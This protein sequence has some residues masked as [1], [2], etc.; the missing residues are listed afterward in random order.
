MQYLTLNNYGVD[1][2]LAEQE[3]VKPAEE[4]TIQEV[5]Q[6]LNNVV[7]EIAIMFGEEKND[8]TELMREITKSILKDILTEVVSRSTTTQPRQ[9]S[10][11][12]QFGRALFTVVSNF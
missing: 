11:M 4:E 12:L 6:K 7:S 8:E 5:T 1:A 2:T 9:S 3:Y 10:P